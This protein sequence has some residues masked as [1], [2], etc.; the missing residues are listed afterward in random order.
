MADIEHEIKVRA[1]PEVVFAAL[2]TPAGMRGWHSS[3]V[4]GSGEV[5][6]DWL[7]RS[8]DA[9]DFVWRVIASDPGSRVRWEC[10]TGPGDSVGTTVEFRLS[11]TGDGRTLV[12]Q[13]HQGW[14]I[15]ADNFRK[16]N[17]LWGALLHHLRQY[18]ETQQS[19]PAFS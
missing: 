4:E 19:A 3:E 6:S 2:S 18:A 10:V 14:P 13:I 8:P 5:G 7:L 1:T 15:D 12:E 16:C 9:P 11:T 17:T